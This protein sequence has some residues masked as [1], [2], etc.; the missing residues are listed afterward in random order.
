MDVEASRGRQAWYLVVLW[1]GLREDHCTP[2]GLMSELRRIRPSSALPIDRVFPETVT[3]KTRRLDFERA[4]IPLV[5]DHGRHADM[6][7]LRSTLG[8]CSREA[9]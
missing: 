1:G 4:G 8:T 6:H 5:D 2:P 3:N 9:A 7:A